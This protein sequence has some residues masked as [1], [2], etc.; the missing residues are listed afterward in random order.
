MSFLTIL[1]LMALLTI[2]VVMAEVMYAYGYY[3]FGYGWSSNRVE[4]KPRGPFGLR[5]QRVLSDIHANGKSPARRMSDSRRQMVD[6][7]S[8]SDLAM[9]PAVTAL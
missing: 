9:R 6:L 4:P 3:G 5:I 7:Y 8:P 1:L 2:A